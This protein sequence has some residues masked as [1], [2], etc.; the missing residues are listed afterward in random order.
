MKVDN[1]KFGTK[2]IKYEVVKNILVSRLLSK[3]QKKKYWLNLF[4]EL[5]YSEDKIASVY[6]V[7]N[8]LNEETI[9]LIQD[10]VNEEGFDGF[11]NNKGK[12]IFIDLKKFNDNIKDIEKEIDK[13]I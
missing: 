3:Y 6:M 11:L 2:G 8:K 4:L 12:I 13:L 7:D 5:E 9:F 10:K 1:Y